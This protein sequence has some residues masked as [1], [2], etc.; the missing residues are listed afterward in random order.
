MGN[1]KNH[2]HQS[3]GSG[4]GRV[5]SPPPHNLSQHLSADKSFG[6]LRK[7]DNTSK[8]LP[9]I[10]LRGS[11]QF[12]NDERFQAGSNLGRLNDD[13]SNNAHHLNSK[14]KLNITGKNQPAVL[15]STNIGLGNQEAPSKNGASDGQI[16]HNLAKHTNQV[17]PSQPF[18]NQGRTTVNANG[19][20]NQDNSKLNFQNNSL[21]SNFD[22]TLGV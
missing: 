12:L 17:G 8:I 2:H 5:G 15:S 13:D 7:S 16:L 1:E 6:Q 19:N 3:E 14:E 10:H 18:S 9:D 21:E 4:F 20:E 11:M 22:K